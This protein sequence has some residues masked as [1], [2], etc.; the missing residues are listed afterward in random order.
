[1]M[2]MIDE[3]RDLDRGLTDQHYDAFL[4]FLGYEQRASF[5]T[6][7]KLNGDEFIKGYYCEYELESDVLS[8]PENRSALQ[9]AGLE[10][11]TLSSGSER[12]GLFNWLRSIPRTNAN[13]L[14]LVI[15]YTSMRRFIYVELLSLLKNNFLNLESVEI[16]FVYSIG[17][18]A[19]KHE[20]KVVQDNIVLAGMEGRVRADF[21]KL[22]VFCL[23]FEPASTL[24][25]YEGLEVDE[26]LPVVADPGASS[27]SAN[28][29]RKMNKTFLAEIARREALKVPLRSVHGFVTEM[30]LGLK[31]YERN[32]D[33]LFVPMGAKPHVLGS[34]ICCLINSNW[35]NIYMRGVPKAPVQVLATSELV[36]TRVT[37]RV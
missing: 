21:P 28:F 1:M 13:R 10:K 35:S 19:G 14:S 29:C 33:I 18:Y 30:L 12:V 6:S 5:F 17:S 37:M 11:V 3:I 4:A 20:P 8:K 32:R 22:G 2:L 16:N 25:M 7:K 26:V 9:Q 24:S 34:A 31:R 36:T 15:D 23:G 27:G